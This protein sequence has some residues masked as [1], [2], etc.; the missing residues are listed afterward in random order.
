MLDAL[1]G[2]VLK[3]KQV[4]DVGT[5]SGVLGLVC[6]I[7]GAHVTVSDSDAS[8]IEHAGNAAKL[9]RVELKGIVSDMFT[10]V[11]GRFNLILFNPPYLPS[12]DYKDKTVDGGALGRNLIN[13]FLDG[14][15]N[16]LQKGGEALLL[17]S[18]LNN[19]KALFDARKEFEFL[20]LKKRALFF[21]ELQVL[22]LRL[23]DD[24]SR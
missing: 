7:R 24:L 1:E 2:T 12:Q 16:H 13:R 17:I 22:R 11:P 18:S 8:A 5:G 4:L 9:L 20:T 23:R 10:D 21:E 19:P 14:L 3:D 6:A 15:P